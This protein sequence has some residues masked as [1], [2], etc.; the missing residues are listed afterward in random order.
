MLK[1]V[2]SVTDGPFERS[3]KRDFGPLFSSYLDPQQTSSYPRAKQR[4]KRERLSAAELRLDKIGRVYEYYVPPLSASE[5]AF[6]HSGWSKDRI[7]VKIALGASGRSAGRIERFDKCGA[8]C[9]VEVASDGS[10]HRVRA[11]Y[12]GD[13][14]CKPCSAARGVKVREKLF[15]LVEGKSLRFLTLT[16]QSGEEN[17]IDLLRRLRESFARLRMAKFWTENVDAGV[18]F[19]EITR[20]R[21]G[22]RWHVHMHCL[23][24]GKWM[25]HARIK[26]AWRTA[27]KG[28]FICDIRTVKSN[29]MAARY[30]AKY[31]TKGLDHSVLKENA[32]LQEAIIALSGTRMVSTFGEWYNADVESEDEE[33]IEWKK[34]G[35]L[36]AIML[37]AAQ[38]EEWA[39]GCLRSLRPGM[40]SSKSKTIAQEEKPDN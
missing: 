5:E 37:A 35:R 40:E 29:E 2:N 13:R 4:K 23:L 11:H 22:N 30:V 10:R 19:V 32:E 17:L 9:V 36:D 18:S 34:L 7:R 3:E 39:I 8:D 14:F 12:C 1:G 33:P 27:S 20:G 28:S 21:W 15:K 26:E 38:G 6:R 31:A 16:M 25:E 24:A